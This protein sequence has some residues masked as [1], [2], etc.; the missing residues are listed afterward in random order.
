MLPRGSQKFDQHTGRTTQASIMNLDEELK[1]RGTSIAALT[2]SFIE[3]TASNPPPSINVE[4]PPAP[5]RT[6]TQPQATGQNIDPNKAFVYTDVEADPPEEV[7]DFVN[8]PSKTSSPPTKASVP[9]S[10]ASNPPSN[11]PKP[12]SKKTYH[13]R[14]PEEIWRFLK[15]Y[16]I[17]GEGG[18]EGVLAYV[19]GEHMF[20]D[21]TKGKEG[22]LA[23]LQYLRD[24]KVKDKSP[25]LKKD[26][27]KQQRTPLKKKDESDED[28]RVRLEIHVA[29]E[30]RNKKYWAKARKL[31]D[32]IIA[33]EKLADTRTG[34]SAEELLKTVEAQAT[35][36]KSQ[37]NEATGRLI[38]AFSTDMASRERLTVSINKV[39]TI[40]EKANKRYNRAMALME[41][42]YKKL[43]IELPEDFDQEEEHEETLPSQ[44]TP[45]Q[46][47]QSSTAIPTAK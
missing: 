31:L 38:N 19:H 18:P 47:T 22:E 1:K 32:D 3:K 40:F 24:L 41:A 13:K 14:K 44:Q 27:Y 35:K 12:S 11:A 2:Q 28:Y 6:R 26:E 20:E 23:V 33:Q 17:H 21:W 29:N 34:A 4:V 30:S 9:P 25:L 15:G 7:L 46:N 37:K 39:C 8:P 36:R 42:F 10:K 43:G 5:K 16:K 45:A